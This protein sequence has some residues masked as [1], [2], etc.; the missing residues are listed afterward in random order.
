MGGTTRTGT[1]GAVITITGI[2][3]IIGITTITTIIIIG[4]ICTTTITTGTT[5]AITI[6]TEPVPTRHSGKTSASAAGNPGGFFLPPNVRGRTIAWRSRADAG[7]QSD[8][9]P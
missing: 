5:T 8:R 1:T 2:T 4:T 6:I 9:S 7:L 3:I